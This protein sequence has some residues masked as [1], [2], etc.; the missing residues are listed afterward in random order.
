MRVNIG[1]VLASVVLVGVAFLTPPPAA[2]EGRIGAP[3]EM[4][5]A[6]SGGIGYIQYD[7]LFAG[8]TSTG[9]YRVP[10]RITVPAD[11][12]RR[13]RTVLVEPPHGAAS[14][15]VLDRY[16]GQDFLFS[17]GFAHAG[18][19]WSTTRFPQGGNLRILDPDAPGVF[20]DGGFKE[21]NGRTDDEIIA[22]FG[23]ALA[24]DANAQRMLGRVER[25]YVSGFSDASDPILRLI[26]AGP[27]AGAFELALPFLA[28]G[29][30][31]QT[32]MAAGRYAG[33][34]IV[35]NSEA[36]G[37]SATFVD[38]GVLPGSYRF[39]AV[40]GSPHI[41]DT[42]VPF[43]SSRTTPASYQPALRSHFLQ[44]HEWA[45]GGAQPPPSIQL[46]TGPDGNLVRDANG[47]AI[48]VEASGRPVPRL[49]FVELGE[50]HYVGTFIGSYD[51]VKSIG[52]L[53]YTSHAAYLRAFEARLADYG[54][55]GYI[56]KED[57][58]DMRR[59]AGLCS[60]L[61]FTETYRDHYDAFVDISPCGG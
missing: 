37:R 53:G 6:T 11:P 15:G 60:P 26:A 59:R 43:V 1:A 8:R 51:T 32:A 20:I 25:R 10:Y 34:L 9:A 28:V 21:Q 14:V 30:D 29:H 47:N 40:A 41:A 24:V 7:G 39:Y 17:R 31:P 23:R 52:D 27:A 55:A 16:L 38:R 13:N 22:D 57:A 4:R 45:R 44:G 56:I 12:A 5:G 3:R 36:E 42:L 2:A 58:D 54:K 48:A 46:K 49:P 19:G 50:A 61:T 18:I 35:L 33:K